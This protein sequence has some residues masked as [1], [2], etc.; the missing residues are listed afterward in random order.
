MEFNS[1]TEEGVVNQLLEDLDKYKPAIMYLD[2][3]IKIYH[4]SVLHYI[5]P[6]FSP[7]KYGDAG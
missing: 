1:N 5:F 4:R 6:I 2:E 3:N 7:L